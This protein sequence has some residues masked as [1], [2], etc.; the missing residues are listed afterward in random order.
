MSNQ[1]RF[2]ALI[3]LIVA[4][5]LIFSLPFHVPRYFRPSVLEAF[6]LTNTALGDIFAVY[7]IT[8]ILA[9]FPGGI[10]ADRFDP[11]CLI[12]VSLILTALGGIYFSS[13]PDT[14]N[15]GILYGYW[16]FTTIL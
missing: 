2:W 13:I 8:A 5:E 7:G 15:L 16:G 12:I 11:K 10:L 6:S 4:G 14:F 3:S 1:R 9:Y